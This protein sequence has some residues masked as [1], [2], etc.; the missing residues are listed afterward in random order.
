MSDHLSRTGNFAF[1]MSRILIYLR[2]GVKFQFGW[3]ELET[4]F[5]HCPFSVPFHVHSIILDCP[6]VVAVLAFL[7]QKNSSE[8]NGFVAK[9]SSFRFPKG[10]GTM[11]LFPI[12]CHVSIIPFGRTNVVLQMI[13]DYSCFCQTSIEASFIDWCCKT[14]CTDYHKYN[15]WCMYS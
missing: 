1:R 2:K 13:W 3:V 12:I 9:L 8:F 5:Y 10:K 7:A 14:S 15:W 4:R 6:R 11:N